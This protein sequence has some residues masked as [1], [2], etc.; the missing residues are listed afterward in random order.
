[1]VEKGKGKKVSGNTVQS[2]T[3]KASK[4]SKAGLLLWFLRIRVLYVYKE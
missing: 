1:V 2:G 4:A 3:V